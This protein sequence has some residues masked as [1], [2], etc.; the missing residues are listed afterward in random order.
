[1]P[2]N[3]TIINCCLKVL[4]HI[5]SSSPRYTPVRKFKN[6]LT[7]ELKKGIQT[8]KYYLIKNFIYVNLTVIDSIIK[9]PRLLSKHYFV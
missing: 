3:S 2:F 8:L 5:I 4:N 6:K 9:N 7:L 1:M